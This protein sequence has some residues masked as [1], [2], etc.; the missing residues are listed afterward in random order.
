MRRIT[1][2]AALLLAPLPALA[3][4]APP[5]DPALAAKPASPATLAAQAA[6]AAALPAE[7]GRDAE[8]AARGFLADRADPVIRTADGRPVWNLNAYDWIKGAAPGTVNPSLWREM[9]VLSHHG[10]FRV[11][12]GVW[13]VRGFDVSNMTVIRGKT[14]W[15]LVDPLTS[16]ETAAAALALVNA[17]LGTR[18]VTAVIYS[19]SHADHFGGVRGVVDEADVRA[20]TVQIVAPAHF[21]EEAASENVIA[22][23]AMGR[24]SI[25]QFGGGLTP[26]AQGQL[27]SGI[28]MAVSAG[29]ISLIAPTQTVDHTGDTR[30]IDGVPMEFQIVSGSEA[31]SEMNLFLPQAKVF[32]SAEMS[33]CTLHNILTPRGAKVRDTHAW[34]GFLDEALHLYGSRAEVDISSHCWPR[35]GEAEV[36]RMLAS[37][38]DNYRYLHDQTVRA[39]NRGQTPAEI[40]EGLVQPAAL[41]ADWF[42]HGY[43][44]TYNHNAKAIYQFYLGWYDA[45][46]ANLDP[47]PPAERA[48]HLV[49][50]IGGADKV[51][52]QARAAMD[53]GDYR[54]SSDLLQ[55]LVFAEP[56]NQAA[57]TA[58]A[59][60]YEQ[61]GYQAESGIWRNQ[62]LVAANEL[63]HG[64]TAPSNSTTSQDLI[65]AVPTQLL[66]DSAATRFDPARLKGRAMAINL[67][68]PERGETAAIELTGT[69][70]IARM[71]PAAA[72]AA[73]IT[74][75][76]R[77]LLALMF[78]KAPLAMVE[79]MGVKVEGDRAA[80]E[81][82]LAAL[83]P[84]PGPF[85]IVTR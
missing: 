10:L 50:A 82:W 21:M 6:V 52:A 62:F 17:T 22:G 67:V 30:T 69:T 39:M 85:D 45:V 56:G 38:R 75:P 27:G 64:R 5:P 41:A 35:F 4:Q 24:R 71:T 70:M 84:M 8:F 59:D 11:A 1:L 23:P 19:H 37:Q 51:L 20:G 7:D 63:R 2:T 78:L 47:W 44:G 36:A 66:F 13:Q 16:R 61:Q 80:V 65:A 58:L 72:P 77:A 48:R 76:R 83:D 68:M 53:K 49:A 26:G 81:A 33:T 29:T 14:G 9:G 46:P 3:D 57:R 31:P 40:A 15:I 54:W 43:Y 25:Y 28:G 12:D 34:A 32:L 79:P 42:N 73:T 60:S 55:N 74:A 18:P